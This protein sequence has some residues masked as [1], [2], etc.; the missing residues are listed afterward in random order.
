[1]NNKVYF[2]INGEDLFLDFMLEEYDFI[3]VFYICRNAQYERY[4]VWATDIDSESYAIVPT[5]VQRL[6]D[7]LSGVLGI[8]E[9][10]LSQR[11]FWNVRCVGEDFKEDLVQQLS[12]SEFP[13][14]TLPKADLNYKMFDKAHKEYAEKIH[15]ELQRLYAEIPLNREVDSETIEELGIY[16]KYDHQRKYSF[17][18]DAV[19]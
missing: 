2:H 5:S 9:F 3:P 10:F 16:E 18:Y 1:M 17:Y 12:I 14:Q 7:M 19:Y 4:A 11:C 15:L 13:L 6:D 8:R